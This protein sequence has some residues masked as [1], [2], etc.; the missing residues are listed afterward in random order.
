MTPPDGMTEAACFISNSVFL[1]VC[2]L[3]WNSS[4]L[5]TSLTRGGMRSLLT[6]STYVQRG[7]HA[8]VTATPS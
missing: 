8:S 3:S 6:P 2:R 1:N 4:T 5:P 7:R